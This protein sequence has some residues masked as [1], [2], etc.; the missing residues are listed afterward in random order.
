MATRKWQD[1]SGND[2]YTTEVVLSGF[3]GVIK[4]LGGKN[5]NGGQQDG[6]ASSGGGSSRTKAPVSNDDMDDSIPFDRRLA[7]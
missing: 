5:E 4:L 7:A 6:G 1:Q 3:D 2:R